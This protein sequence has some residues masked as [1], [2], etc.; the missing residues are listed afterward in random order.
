MATAPRIPA[1]RRA[2]EALALVLWLSAAS[3]AAQHYKVLFNFNGID[4]YAPLGGVTLDD[5]G[6]LYGAAGNGGTGECTNGCGLVFELYPMLDGD[7]TE[8][9]LYSFQGAP[10]GEGPGGNVFIG[11][12]GGLF[13]TTTFGGTN[14]KGTVFRLTKGT[15]G[16]EEKVLYSF[17]YVGYCPHIPESGVVRD[18][19]G[20]LYGTAFEAYELS[21]TENGWREDTL[22]SFKDGHDGALPFAGLILD[23]KGNL[24]GTTYGGGYGCSNTSS[25]GTVYE[26][27]P[28]LD[29]KWIHTVLFRFNGKN[30][31]FPGAGALYM[32]SNGALY[33]TTEGGGKYAGVLFRLTPQSNGQWNFAILHNFLQGS[34]G[35]EPD[36]GV[37]MDTLGNLYGTTTGGGGPSGCG[38][39]YKL[40]PTENDKWSYSVLH[41]FGGNGDGCFASGNLVIDQQGNLYGSLILGGEYGYGVVFEYSTIPSPQ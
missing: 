38:V 24:Y 12:D 23:P 6:R 26:L 27:S 15:R 30:G 17:C 35:Y 9:I 5:T 33:G 4:G 40:S 22:Y 2:L 20:N 39:L 36:A 1:P 31:Q 14:D 7:W 34:Q 41:T 10:D 29:G 11:P 13:G 16:W 21:P 3:Q 37:V 19:A 18:N 28:G 25:C 32:D 8:E